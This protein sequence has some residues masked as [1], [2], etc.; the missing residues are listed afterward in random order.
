MSN[1]VSVGLFK[2]LPKLK[3]IFKFPK[4][5][6]STFIEMRHSFSILVFTFVFGT[7]FQ[8]LTLNAQNQKLR[9]EP[10]VL[11]MGDINYFNNDPFIF[12]YE[13][14]GQAPFNF[15]PASVKED[16][17]IIIPAGSFRYGNNGMVRV[18]YYPK[19]LGPFEKEIQVFTNM[20]SKPITLVVRGNIK[21]FAS[22]V[23]NE[24]PADTP[25]ATYRQ[26]IF[27][28]DLITKLPLYNAHVTLIDTI[29]I[30]RAKQYTTKEGI[31]T[32]DIP[33][34]PYNLY[35]K[36]QN[37]DPVFKAQVFTE[38]EP[39]IGVGM[40][41]LDG[42]DF[43]F[44]DALVPLSTEEYAPNN[45]VFLVDVSSS[46]ADD[47]KLELL[48]E[49]ISLLVSVMRDI[50]YLTLIA[51]SNTDSLVIPTTKVKTKE[52]IYM[53]LAELSPFGKTNGLKGLQKAYDLAELNFLKE[54]NNQI[55]IAT[56]GDFNNPGHTIDS[57]LELVEAKAE[58]ELKLSVIGFGDDKKAKKT[59]KK[60]AEAGLGQYI[61]F[62][63]EDKYDLRLIEEIKRQS[64]LR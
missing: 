46:M 23:L 29:D 34:G 26:G 21:S 54:G 17:Q 27:V 35:I 43:S 5:I 12:E 20:G 52:V 11:D 24:K 41:P 8:S 60:M 6:H 51:Y 33:A 44:E 37:Y 15:L 50:D 56:D 22:T 47:N 36:K 16:L 32:A 62:T 38:A 59:M 2:E 48:K 40:Y 45:V 64:A 53:S 42:F 31:F 30:V 4:F 18:V 7:L 14:K 9:F 57:L 39:Y 3:Q 1:I 28:F 49:S 63:G 10:M 61:H 19:E 58:K 13:Y 25:E 55:F